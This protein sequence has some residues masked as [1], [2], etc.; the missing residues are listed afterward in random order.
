[1]L[2]S[3]PLSRQRIPCVIVLPNGAVSVFA[4]RTGWSQ[5]RTVEPNPC[6]PESNEHMMFPSLSRF[7]PAGLLLLRLM[8][9]IVFID[10]GWNDL[11]S[12]AERAQSIGK[13]RNF[14]IFLGTAEVLGGGGVVLGIWPQLAALGLILVSL[15]AIYEKIF[16]WTRNSG[17]TKHTAGTT[18][19]CFW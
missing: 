17:A 10:S 13:S 1:M 7:L 4:L 19:S 16:V 15:G 14:T 8:V 9:G 6:W 18:T 5:A 3:A 2:V 12:P 11:R